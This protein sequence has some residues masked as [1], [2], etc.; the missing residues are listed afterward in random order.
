[1]NEESEP[2]E[3]SSNALDGNDTF[4]VALREIEALVRLNGFSIHDVPYDG[5]S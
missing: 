5:T 1:M 2:M 4:S 3:C